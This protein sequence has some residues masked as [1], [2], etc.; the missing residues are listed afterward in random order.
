M[1]EH[2]QAV[3]RLRAATVP[4]RVTGRPRRSDWDAAE[5]IEIPGAWVASSSSIN[6]G[7]A[8]RQQVITDKSLYCSPDYDVQKGDRI[9]DG[10]DTYTVTSKP[11]ADRN[12]FT[13]WQPTQEIPLE[14]VEG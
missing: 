2:G 13:G 11:S 6:S 7:D 8:T 9:V 14:L 4:D 12:P 5:Q 1:F 3:V 10:G